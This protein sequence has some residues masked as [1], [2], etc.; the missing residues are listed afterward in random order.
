MDTA[1]NVLCRPTFSQIGVPYFDLKS[2]PVPAAK[3]RNWGFI[4]TKGEWVVRPQFEYAGYFHNGL[5]KVIVKDKTGYI[6]QDCTMAIEPRFE[7]GDYFFDTITLVFEN[8]QSQYINTRGEILF[9]EKFGV[10]VILQ[11]EKNSFCSNSQI[12]GSKLGLAPVVGE[13]VISLPRSLKRSRALLGS[14][15]VRNK[16]ADHKLMKQWRGGAKGV[17]PS[18]VSLCRRCQE[19]PT[20]EPLAVLDRQAAV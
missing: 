19:K 18:S 15:S 12:A 20:N 2:E 1:G 5:A 10:I 8:N 14:N 16:T 13:S 9:G 17:P 3:G 7:G 11:A 6:R 4:N